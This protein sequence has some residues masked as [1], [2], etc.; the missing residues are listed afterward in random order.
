MTRQLPA[1]SLQRIATLERL[2]FEL[3]QRIQLL[4]RRPT[5]RKESEQMRKRLE[6]Q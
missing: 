2:M 3:A 1:T 4:E 6:K 5:K